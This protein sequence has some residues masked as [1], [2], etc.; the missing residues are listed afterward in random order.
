MRLTHLQM[1]G[2]SIAESLERKRVSHCIRWLMFRLRQAEVRPENSHHCAG[3]RKERKFALRAGQDVCCPAIPLSEAKAKLSRYGQL[4]RDEPVVAT[5]NGRL[6][7][8]LVPLEE[9]V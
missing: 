2:E 1:L 9:E 3:R 4:C 6:S 5:V 8:R 7:F